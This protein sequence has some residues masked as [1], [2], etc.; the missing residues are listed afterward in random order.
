M[1]KEPESW[2]LIVEMKKNP[3]ELNE[4]WIEL[5]NTELVSKSSW[6]GKQAKTRD[7]RTIVDCEMKELKISIELKVEMLLL[8]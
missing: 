2:L 6:I 1:W 8:R 7:Y 4:T 5:C 3:T